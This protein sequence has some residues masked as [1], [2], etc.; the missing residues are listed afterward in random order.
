[1]FDWNMSEQVFENLGQC[2][3]HRATIYILME[4]YL[5]DFQAVKTTGADIENYWN[6]RPGPT[7]SRLQDHNERIYRHMAKLTHTDMP[8]GFIN[9]REVLDKYNKEERTNL[10]WHEFVW[11]FYRQWLTHINRE[12]C[13]IRAKIAQL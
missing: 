10:A 6:F 11:E 12:E 4:R 1:M 3:W 2:Q 5:Y 7:L 8:A 9:V 13:R